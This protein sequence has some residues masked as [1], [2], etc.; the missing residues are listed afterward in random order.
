MPPGGGRET[1]GDVARAEAQRQGQLYFGDVDHEVRRLLTDLPPDAR[2]E[3][4]LVC[5]ERAMARHVAQPP[6]EQRTFTLEWRP[7]LT[8]I[9]A[10]LPG[11]VTAE[12]DV[13]S[14]LDA[15]HAGPYDHDDGPDGPDDADDDAAAAAIYAA[16]C[17][18]SGK[19]EL[20]WWA[21]SRVVEMALADAAGDDRAA[22]T[23]ESLA[24]ENLDPGVQAELRRQ[25][26]DLAALGRGERLVDRPTV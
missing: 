1:W 14:A 9:R 6:S 2:R 13:R 10:G 25:L 11:D 19:A 21:A 5:A 26:D 23:P 17:F 3:F 12:A 22:P 24:R 8:A 20:A 16:E 7:I 18:L 4:A 15:F